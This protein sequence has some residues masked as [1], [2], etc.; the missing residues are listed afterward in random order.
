MKRR[1]FTVIIAVFIF[2]IS[3]FSVAGCRRNK[4]FTVTFKAGNE[5]AY[6]YLGEDVQTVKSSDQIVEPVFVCKGYNFVGWDSSISDIKED[7]VVT[8]RWSQYKFSVTFYGNGGI[9]DNGESIVTEQVDSGINIIPPDF[10]KTGYDLS[11]DKDFYLLTESCEI[12]ATW[13]AKEYSLSFLDSNGETLDG[14]E[15]VKAVYDKPINLPMKP[16]KD[17]KKFA[18]W[19]DANGNYID[20]NLSWTHDGNVQAYAVWA[21]LNEYVI[22]YDLD[23]A[24]FND[25]EIYK[26]TNATEE[27][28]IRDPFRPG[29]RFTGWTVNGGAVKQSNELV[30]TDFTGDTLLKANW[31][32]L[33]YHIT[34]SLS[35]GETLVDGVN[36]EKWVYYGDKVGV[37]PVAIKK[38]YVFVGWSFDGS[39]ITDDF[40]WEKSYDASL[41]PVFKRIYTVKFSLTAIVRNS[42]VKCSIKNL[43]DVKLNEGQDFES[44]EKNILEGESFAR[45]GL[46]IF[47]IVVEDDS[48][49]YTFKNYWEFI[50]ESGVKRR[51]YADTIL[52]KENFVGAEVN[53]IILLRPGCRANWTPTY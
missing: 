12:S 37:L 27:I 13:T 44:Y 41:I 4:E 49:E 10:K 33:P 6:L 11:W 38:G 3:A 53:G 25:N 22:E 19:V 43:G 32:V 46:A 2:I 17:G 16:I 9:L 47:P 14:V 34:Y 28:H 1:V 36:N 5:Q 52:N 18:R 15:S 20:S 40:V 42:E 48:E 26:F 31:A 50:S 35:S 24:T 45:N 51:V 21:D 29:Y 39:F 8:A 30:R 7:R 23:G